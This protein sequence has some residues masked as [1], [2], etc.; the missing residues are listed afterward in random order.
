MAARDGQPPARLG[1]LGRD[2]EADGLEVERPGG[3]ALC[4]R[5]DLRENGRDVDAAVRRRVRGQPTG[6]PSPAASAAVLLA[7]T[8]LV[9]G[10]G[11][12]D[13]PLAE[14]ALA[15]LGRPPG[16]L[17]LL[18]CLEVLTPARTSSSP[19]ESAASF[20]ALLRSGRGDDPAGGGRSLLPRQARC[21][22]AGAQLVTTDT[23]EAPELVIA[24]IS[25]IEPDEVA[26]AYPDIP[27]VGFTSHTDTAGLRRAHAAGFDQVLAKSALVERAPRAD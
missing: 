23:A 6:A 9:P 10:D 27:I 2:L 1:G 3:D 13:E 14:V 15:C 19:A 26:D 20:T 16:G 5:V 21:A 8:R 11:D 7:A 4:G 25:R 18:V 22:A 12:M 24:D 17:E